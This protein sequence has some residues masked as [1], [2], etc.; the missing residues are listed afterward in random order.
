MFSLK[1]FLEPFQAWRLITYSMKKQVGSITFVLRKIGQLTISVN[2]SAYVRPLQQ[3]PSPYLIGAHLQPDFSP[4]LLQLV[5]CELP[6]VSLSLLW[7]QL[8]P[9]IA[10][11]LGLQPGRGI[12]RL[13]V[14]TG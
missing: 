7:P 3:S 14:E 12:L 11:L 10:M 1:A 5:L 6:G 2:K 9:F 4:P 8:G 13:P